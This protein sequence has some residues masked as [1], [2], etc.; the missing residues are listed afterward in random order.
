MNKEGIIKKLLLVILMFLFFNTIVLAAEGSN[1]F[2]G[3]TMASPG[4]TISVEIEIDSK[5]TID[6]YDATVSYESDVLELLSIENKSSWKGNNSVKNSPLELAFT[7]ENS[8]SGQTVVAVLKFKVKEK[9]TKTETTITL[10]GRT[11][12]ES[13]GIGNVLEKYTKKI[14]IKSTDNYLTDLKINGETVLNFSS[15]NYSYEIP[16]NGETISA[17]IEATLSD[18]TATFKK[19][20]GPR[21]K[22][23]DYGSNEMKIIVV[24]A[25]G[26]ER[27][28]LINIIREDSR[29]TSNSLNK[30]ILNSGNIKFA[31]D[32]AKYKAADYTTDNPKYKIKTYK[33][34]TLDVVASASDEKAKVKIDQ[35]DKLAIGMNKV[36]ITVTSEAGT[37]KVYILNIENVDKAIDTTLKSIEILGV[38]AKL[39]FKKDVFD[40][41]LV[42]KTNFK[43]NL[44]IKETKNDEDN[45]DVQIKYAEKE[46]S[47][48]DLKV[49]SVIKIIVYSNVDNSESV[50]TITMVKDTRINFFFLVS[51]IIFIVLLI[52]FITMLIKNKKIKKEIALK[53]EELAKTK[54]VLKK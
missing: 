36:T 13:D 31:L 16:K 19:D 32:D 54:E 26:E 40:Y 43:D 30:I 29:G 17:T 12:L 23:L 35:P 14:D 39:N 51:I 3:P 34:E 42:F 1:Y 27:T 45:D 33:L 21:Q 53:Q 25:S 7:R 5:E 11:M 37:E 22:S 10:E 48:K 6:K 15:K 41:E 47:M 50:Y 24:S 4:Q 8:V 2:T 44:I 28:Y 46:A 20:F 18:N 38:D 52:V 49:G 9:I